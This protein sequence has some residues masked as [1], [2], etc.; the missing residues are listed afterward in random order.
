MKDNRFLILFL[1]LL[2]C[3]LGAGTAAATTIGQLE[4]RYRQAFNAGDYQRA[5][6]EATRL[7]NAAKATFGKNHTD[8]A[9][10]L[11]MLG[12][13]LSTLGRYANARTCFEEALRI[14]E[15]AFGKNHQTVGATAFNLGLTQSNEDDFVA[16]ERNFQRAATILGRPE[17]N[18]VYLAKV[19]SSLGY[20]HS[21]FGRYEE[22][23]EEHKRALK[24]EIQLLSPDDS[25]LV[26]TLTSLAQSYGQTGKYDLAADTARQ[27]AEIAERS[28]GREHPAV[29]A[30]LETLA[31][32]CTELGKYSEAKV[33]YERMLTITEKSFGTV[34]GRVAVTLNGIARLLA[35]QGK[36]SESESLYLKALD[37]AEAAGETA[38]TLEEILT[39][40]GDLYK[41]QGRYLDAQKVLGRALEIE[42]TADPGDPAGL[43]LAYSN[44]A[45]VY[46]EAGNLNEAQTLYAGALDIGVK[47]LGSSHPDVATFKQNLA[48]TYAKAGKYSEAELLYADA[49]KAT[50]ASLGYQHPTLAFIEEHRADNLRQAGRIDEALQ[51]A[52]QASA[53]TVSHLSEELTKSQGQETAPLGRKQSDRFIKHVV[54][55]AAAL[56]KADVTHAIADDEAF[57]ISQWA[58]QSSAA[59]AVSQMAA[60]N[61]FAAP[62][63]QAI[64]KYQDLVVAYKELDKHYIEALSASTHNW[65][66]TANLRDEL[67]TC[68]QRLQK[69]KQR[70]EQDF[71]A[72]AGLAFPRPIS[73]SAAQG[74]LSEQ[75]ALIFWAVGRDETF[76]FAVTATG[77]E[78]KKISIGRDE[79]TRRVIEFR[80]GLS[81]DDGKLFNLT[82]A[83]ELYDTLLGPVSKFIDQSPQWLAVAPGPL[84]SLPLHLLLVDKPVSSPNTTNAEAYR[85]APWLFRR[86]A[87][88][89]LPSVGSLSA[90]RKV[91]VRNAAVK[92]LIGFGDPVFQS[93]SLGHPRARAAMRGYQDYWSGSQVDRD[94]LMYGLAPLPETADELNAVG[95]SLGAKSS[96]IFLG[97]AASEKN[98]KQLPLDEY[99]IIYF[100]THALVAGDVVGL[101]EPALALTLPENSTPLDDGLLS[102][103]EVTA[104]RLNADWVVLSACNT[105]AGDSVGAEAL[106]GLARAFFYA[107]ARSLLVSHWSVS[108][109]ATTELMISIF[110][111]VRQD[112]SIGRAEAVRRGMNAY[113]DNA[114]TP[115]SLLPSM[116]GAFFL[117]GEGVRP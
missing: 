61:Q 42:R 45:N 108:S 99:R 40:L 83:H 11:T 115:Q 33:I 75:E 18:K 92:P 50:A 70:L 41:D 9:A 6:T 44:L 1:S 14:E 91:N 30:P 104:L 101:G 95:S 13:T 23:I 46:S 27:A 57:E 72:Y 66:L 116:W 69:A 117:V 112:S 87:I 86:H 81:I 84:S 38:S 73:I 19:L 12:T 10:A 98:V 103:S 26:G 113:L 106:S 71:P 88:S 56:D 65:V 2:I 22:A 21:R 54:T 15:K 35:L 90:L 107:G 16:A 77:F 25:E 109:T 93:R 29:L 31:V 20:L 67:A 82:G 24:I 59:V 78:W 79:L 74:L 47:A 68:N 48:F 17:G 51:H 36:A 100:T 28:S 85:E 64:R 97:E 102:T 58:S 34:S 32:A 76:V 114:S 62:L 110:N 37:M 53:V 63:G 111:I 94:A 80:Q 43:A 7:V 105:A 96:D 8:Y 3:L 52:R 4:N 60:R 39:G 5:L 55:L 89:V 49:A